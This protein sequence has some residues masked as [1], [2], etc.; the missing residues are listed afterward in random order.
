MT[1]TLTREEAQQVLD[2]LERGRSQIMGVLVQ[3]DQDAAIET[4][5]A[6]IERSEVAR[7]GP[8]REWARISRIDK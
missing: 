5:R 7:K 3:Q 8:V 4:F 2:A 6:R 1:I